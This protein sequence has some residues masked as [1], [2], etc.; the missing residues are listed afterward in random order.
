MLRSILVPLDGSQLAERAL[1]YATAI[2]VPTGARLIL[3][4]AIKA[5]DTKGVAA[6]YL[7]D[8]AEELR[9]RGFVCETVTPHGSPAEWIAAEA[10]VGPVDLVTMT[11]HGRSG[12]GRWLFG[13]VAES[14][15]ASSP[16]PVLVE[17]AWQPIRRESLLTDQPTLLVP[18]DGSTFAE[19]ALE[20][21]AGLA[22]DLGAELVLVRVEHASTGVLRDE[23][24]RTIAYLDELEDRT[25]QL[26]GDYL[27]QLASG[28]RRRWPG[29]PIHTKVQF[30]IPAASIAEAATTTGAALVFMAT[31]GRTGLRRAVMGSVAGQLLERGSTPLVLI[32][33]S[34]TPTTLVPDSA[35]RSGNS[36]SRRIPSTPRTV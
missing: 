17:R 4:R 12:P 13:S 34:A 25:E 10:G 26:A 5:S 7:F 31:H 20:P 15:V 11:T 32:R 22:E 8:T 27:G 18:L 23:Y 21:A 6:R 35:A 1:A 30:G 3:M 29:V 19:S 2:S 33:P 14:V 28:A 9:A 36:E 24:G 16:V